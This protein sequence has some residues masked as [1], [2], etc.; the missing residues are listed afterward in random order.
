MSKFK[1]GDRV[2]IVVD[3]LSYGAFYG[4]AYKIGDLAT[5][6]RLE[7]DNCPIIELDR[8]YD[9]YNQIVGINDVEVFAD[10][11]TPTESVINEITIDGVRYTLTRVENQ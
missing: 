2:K 1:I 9:S 8:F 3:V 6:V 4:Y 10:N 7:S 5:V 11:F